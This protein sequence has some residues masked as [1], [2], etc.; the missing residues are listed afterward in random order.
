MKRQKSTRDSL[1]GHRRLQ[2][3]HREGAREPRTP[4]VDGYARRGRAQDG[5][6]SA[7]SIA[8]QISCKHGHCQR[9]KAWDSLTASEKDTY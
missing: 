5:P 2:T 4:H 9:E 8:V 6:R 3:V 1:M 7:S